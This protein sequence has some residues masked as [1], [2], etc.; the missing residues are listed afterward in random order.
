MPFKVIDNKL[1]KKYS[2]IWETV[3]SLMNVKF[4]SEPVYGDKDK[5]I[6]TKIKSYGDEINSNFQDKKVPKKLHHISV[7]HW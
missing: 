5:Y 1:L 6:I 4:D 3:S 2:K 7:Y